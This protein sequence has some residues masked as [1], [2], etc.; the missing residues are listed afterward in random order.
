[1]NVIVEL[2]WKFSPPNYFVKEFEIPCKLC[3]MNISVDKVKARIDSDIYNA[4]PTMREELHELLNNIFLGLQP[5]KHSA[6]ELSESTITRIHSDGRKD[7]ELR[8]QCAVFTFTGYPPEIQITDK[9]GN[10]VYNSKNDQIERE[11]NLMNLVVKHNTDSLLK[12]LHQSYYAAVRDSSNEL[13]HLFEIREALDEKFKGKKN[14]TKILNIKNEWDSIGTLCNNREI[15]Q[16]R[17]RGQHLGTLTDATEEEL[18]KARN[19]AKNMIFAYRNYL[20]ATS[21]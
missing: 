7:Y 6:Y 16:G 21:E 1:M 20:E 10:V 19:S 14:A 13:V 11:K 17:H 4:N 2:E 8:P 15:K 3:T 12:K 18:N 5:L 9:N